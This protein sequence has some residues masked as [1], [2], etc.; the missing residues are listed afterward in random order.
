M[1]TLT[2]IFL[3]LLCSLAS[4]AQENTFKRLDAIALWP[5]QNIDQNEI[6]K[7]IQTVGVF[8]KV[9]TPAIIPYLPPKDKANGTSIIICPGGGYHALAWRHHVELLA[10]LFTSKGIALI[11]L[12]YRT[13]H[14]GNTIP[15]DPLKDFNQAIKLVKQNAKEWNLNKDK[16]VGLG[17]S[18]GSNL[19]LQYACQK[20]GE[21]IKY[22]NFLCLWP[23][24][25]TPSQYKLQK[26]GLDV[27]LFTSNDDKIA[28]PKFSLEMAE[29]F[30]ESRSKAK[31]IH[32]PKG[33]HAAY[34]FYHNGPQID[35]TAD[36]LKWLSERD[37]VKLDNHP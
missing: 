17:F 10:P 22:L 19:I 23:Y 24:Y 34:N 13:S 14:A 15:D 16:I 4:L 9:T 8:T 3:I 31:L 29:I 2:S 11:G 18:A 28:P 25:K 32:H 33:T 26:S 35:W 6:V 5:G 20:E 1:H 36:F 27:I 37:L 12:K 30:N 7:T 21:K